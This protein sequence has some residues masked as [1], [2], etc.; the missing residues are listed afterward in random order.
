[1]PLTISEVNISFIKPNN[2]LIGFASLIINGGF[3]IS[4]IGIHQR[5]DGTGYRLTYPTK[6]QVN[7]C[8]PINKETSL[9]IEKAVIT[10]LKDVMSKTNVGY[11]SN[12]HE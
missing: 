10:K 4:S 5:L 2:G 11:D 9:A 6:Q 12:N 3:Y 7:I 1:M 8:H